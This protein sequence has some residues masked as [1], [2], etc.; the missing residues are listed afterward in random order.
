MKNIFVTLSILSCVFLGALEAAPQKK[1]VSKQLVAKNERQIL[2]NN[3]AQINAV[4]S[5]RFIA[6]N[7]FNSSARRNAVKA[8]ITD[9]LRS[10]GTSTA[11]QLLK[12]F[13]ANGF[14]DFI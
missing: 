5:E 14:K 8:G 6:G 4:I 10:V 12:E 7:A 9:Y 11:L 3:C 2:L 1:R 13:E